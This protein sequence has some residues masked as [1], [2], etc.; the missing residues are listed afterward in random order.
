MYTSVL[1]LTTLAALAAAQVGPADMMDQPKVLAEG[2][3]RT[4]TGQGSAPTA[5]AESNNDSANANQQDSNNADAEVEADNKNQHGH[6]KGHGDSHHDAA[7]AHANSKANSAVN[8]HLKAHPHSGDDEDDLL[9]EDL[10]GKDE[11]EGA[12]A[13]AAATGSL[14][15]VLAM[16]A[17]LYSL[18]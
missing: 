17:G 16:T 5:G 11:V 10:A 2:H 12:A 15:V 14:A 6:A 7:S 1:L 3:A 9:D 8:K 4:V 18:F 13:S